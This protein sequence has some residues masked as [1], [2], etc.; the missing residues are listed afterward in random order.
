MTVK[1]REI[2]EAV[3]VLAEHQNIRVTVSSSLK[4]SGIAGVATFIGGLVITSM[5]S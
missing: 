2:I 1:T 3:S 5:L 4:A